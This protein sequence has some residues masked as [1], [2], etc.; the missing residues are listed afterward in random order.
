MRKIQLILILILLSFQ[1]SFSQEVKVKELWDKLELG[2]TQFN[3]GNYDKAEVIFDEVIGQAE[4]GH[5]EEFIPDAYLYRA[6]CNI[7]LKSEKKVCDDLE[8]A[9]SLKVVDAFS[10]AKQNCP[11]LLSP[12]LESEWSSQVGSKHFWDKEYLESIPYFDKAIELNPSNK[13]A[14]SSRALALK[15]TKQ[16]ERA[17]VDYNILIQMDNENPGYYHARGEVLFEL[18]RYEE[19]ILDLDK[20]LALEPDNVFANLTRGK[21]YSSLKN[22]KKAITDF[23]KVIKDLPLGDVYLERAKAYLGLGDKT[24]AC[25][26]L[27]QIKKDELTDEIN[28][29]IKNCAPQ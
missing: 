26:D 8:K 24:R 6:K 2:V 17:L 25:K 27:K 1:T 19:T 5:A 16:P 12:Q 28:S 4:N 21:S 10:I 20:A 11:T 9:I 7:Q 13:S 29:L 3:L 22:Y 18:Q 14:L 23:D 15:F